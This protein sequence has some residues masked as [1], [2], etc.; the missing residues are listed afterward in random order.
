[1]VLIN[2]LDCNSEFST[3]LGKWFAS[4]PILP[5]IV[6]KPNEIQINLSINII[7]DMKYRLNVVLI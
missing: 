5:L 2:K 6:I 7:A 4:P 1:M 3:K